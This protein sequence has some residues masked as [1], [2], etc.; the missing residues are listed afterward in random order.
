MLYNACDLLTH[1]AGVGGNGMEH[2]VQVVLVVQQPAQREGLRS[3]LE[4]CD[5]VEVVAQADDAIMGGQA[6][7]AHQ[8][9]LVVWDCQLAQ[10]GYR[11]I[12]P[13]VKRQ[14]PETQVLAFGPLEKECVLDM[15][16]AG[17]VG[18][19]EYGEALDKIVDAVLKVGQGGQW[20][21]PTVLPFL[22]LLTQATSPVELPVLPQ[23]P[24]LD[25]LLTPRQLEVLDEA[26]RGKS[27]KAIAHALKIRPKTVEDHLSAIF[28]RLQ[29]SGRAGAVAL[30]VRWQM[31][32][33]SANAADQG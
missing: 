15:V 12:I 11:A 1:W 6:L 25:T 22:I 33:Q 9:N 28:E 20:Y 26:A 8:P 31:Q 3:A 23:T 16:Q 27:T 10:D 2:P 7:V 29:V 24:V 4:M 19:V 32:R 14:S 30:Y 13:A 5:A 21:S 17:A 18:Y